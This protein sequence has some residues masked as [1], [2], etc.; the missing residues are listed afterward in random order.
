MNDSNRSIFHDTKPS[1]RDLS[2]LRRLYRHRDS[3]S[4]VESARADGGFFD[5]TTLPER[6][7]DETFSTTESV[8]S[9]PTGDGGRVVTFI[10]WIDESEAEQGRGLTP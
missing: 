5:P 8:R 10:T 1:D 7:D 3:R 4:S 6:P 2:K 9:E